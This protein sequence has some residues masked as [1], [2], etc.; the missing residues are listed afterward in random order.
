MAKELFTIGYEGMSLDGFVS[1]L[2][3]FAINY[4]IDIRE[5]PVSRKPGFSK[6]E[7][8][9][10]LSR[11]NVRYVHL[12][13][14]GSPRPIREEL[15]RNYDYQLFFGSMKKYLATRREAIEIAYRYIADNSCCLLC[16]ERVAEQCHRKLVAEI[17]KERDGNRLRIIN[18]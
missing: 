8:A 10:T 5:N 15:K 3:N 2:K 9:E 4:V 16:F 13:E 17:I 18:I 7:L 11:E 12:R 6:T 14:L 1:R